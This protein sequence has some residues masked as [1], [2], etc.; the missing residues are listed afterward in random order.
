MDTF[1]PQPLSASVSLGSARCSFPQCSISPQDTSNGP[2]WPLAKTSKTCEPKEDLSFFQLLSPGILSQQI[3]TGIRQ[4][5]YLG[6]LQRAFCDKCMEVFPTGQWRMCLE[7]VGGP[8]WLWTGFCWVLCEMPFHFHC[9]QQSA[10]TSLTTCTQSPALS[11]TPPFTITLLLFLGKAWYRRGYSY[12][13][14]CPACPSESHL[15]NPCTPFNS[16]DQ[17]RMF[18]AVLIHVY[19][20]MCAH[21]CACIYMHVEAKWYLWVSSFRSLPPSHWPG[22]HHTD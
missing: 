10:W 2:R 18:T 1:C 17:G 12:C 7:E 14:A 22:V 13:R 16:L 21:V 11:W 19:M 20:L 6:T 4:H 15:V 8:L 3:H 5:G 9:L